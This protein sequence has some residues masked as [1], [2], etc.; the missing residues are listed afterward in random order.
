M[1]QD[2]VFR[3]DHFSGELPLFPLS[4]AVF[5]PQTLWPLHVFENRY[6]ALLREALEGERLIGMA[7]LKPGWENT[8]HDSPDIFP[9]GCLARIV[10]E[11]R[12]HD[13]RY[14]IILMGL[15][16]VRIVC[17]I[18][19][20][21]YRRAAVKIL[22]DSYKY[23][24]AGARRIIEI[25]NQLTGVYM[26]LCERLCGDRDKVRKILESP[27]PLGLLVDLLTATL[28]F[29][30]YKKQ[31]ILAQTDVA[32]RAQ[33]L[34]GLLSEPQYEPAACRDPLSEFRLRFGLN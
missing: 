10:K 29:D 24:D 31:E 2:L 27:L 14:N 16:R 7:L 21:P 17:E 8:Y 22:K 1:R 20:S 19:K 30:I 15:H 4:N 13:G 12:L 23:S 33:L 34:F 28:K 26:E 11:T 25:R 3:L 6:R 9:V 32:R 5:F 18:Q